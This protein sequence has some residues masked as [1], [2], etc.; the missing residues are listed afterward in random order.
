MR[1][2]AVTEVTNLGPLAPRFEP[3]RLRAILL[4]PRKRPVRLWR[5]WHTRRA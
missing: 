3:A 1:H 5:N 2:R 4:L